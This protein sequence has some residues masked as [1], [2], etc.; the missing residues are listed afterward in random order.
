VTTVAAT[1]MELAARREKNRGVEYLWDVREVESDFSRN[2]NERVV[3]VLSI[4]HSKAGINYFTY[5]RTN[6]DHFNVSFGNETRAD[7]LDREGNVIGSVQSFKLFSAF[8]LFRIA[9][10]NRYSAKKL[11]DAEAEAVKRFVELYEAG[12]ARL[13]QIFDGRGADGSGAE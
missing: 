3:A 8:G 2:G 11:R 4:S 6:E 10:G 7:M 12:D 13:H 9:A 5:E 1:I